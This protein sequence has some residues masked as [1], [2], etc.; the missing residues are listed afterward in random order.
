MMSPKPPP[1]FVVPGMHV[2]CFPN[3]A[4]NDNTLECFFDSTCFNT[5]AQWISTLPVTSWPK[6]LN[7]SIKS[8]FLPTTTI[9]SLLEQNMVEEW[10]NV[11]NFSGYYAACSPASCTYT[12][13]KHSGIFH[14]LTT[15]IGS[16][17]GLMVVLRIIAPQLVK[18]HSL[19]ADYMSKRTKPDTSVQMQQLG[20]ISRC[21]LVAFSRLHMV[22]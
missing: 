17:G 21:F 1:V 13:T 15:L 20:M 14:I 11:T 2:G 9:G 3:D 10:Q 5:P 12:M 18:L 16:L 22:Q 4:M 8:H 19:L 7:S 6:P